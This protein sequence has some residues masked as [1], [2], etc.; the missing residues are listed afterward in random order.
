MAT[1]RARVEMQSSPDLGPG[2]LVAMAPEI[3][4][5]DQVGGR[6]DAAGRGGPDVGEEET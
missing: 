5:L 4:S 2:R 6:A 3:P 1:E